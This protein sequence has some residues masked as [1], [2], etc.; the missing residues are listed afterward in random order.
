VDAVGAAA[1]LLG[2]LL[3]DSDELRGEPEAHHLEFD[4]GL[5]AGRDVGS[6]DLLPRSHVLRLAR[7]R[8]SRVP[9]RRPGGGRAREHLQGIAGAKSAASGAGFSELRSRRGGSQVRAAGMVSGGGRPRRAPAQASGR[10]CRGAYG[11]VAV[12]FRRR[13]GHRAGRRGRSAGRSR[14]EASQRRWSLIRPVAGWMSVGAP[15]T[16]R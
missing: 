15:A 8:A 10:A 13:P 2:V 9:R 14:N 12:P 4:R 5:W 16:G 6:P 1:E 11:I 3:H 7:G